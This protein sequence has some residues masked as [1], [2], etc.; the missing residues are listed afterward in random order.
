MLLLSYRLVKSN[1]KARLRLGY[2]IAISVNLM[3]KTDLK[4][5]VL[6]G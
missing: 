4:F 1:F 3:D 5:S 2:I 6:Q